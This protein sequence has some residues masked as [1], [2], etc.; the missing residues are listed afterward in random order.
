MCAA[1]AASSSQRFQMPHML[2]RVRALLQETSPAPAAEV[3]APAEAGAGLPPAD[4]AAAPATTGAWM[5]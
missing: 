5:V 2:K 4:L 1:A 3:A